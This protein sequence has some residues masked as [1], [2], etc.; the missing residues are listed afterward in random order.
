MRQ[1][2]NFACDWRPV[3][4]KAASFFDS[5]LPEQIFKLKNEK[6]IKKSEKLRDICVS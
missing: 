3:Q 4:C 1:N 5:T 2:S 6:A